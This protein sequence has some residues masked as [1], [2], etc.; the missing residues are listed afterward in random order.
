M[1]VGS[2]GTNVNSDAARNLA[3]TLPQR[4]ATTLREAKHSKTN[5]PLFEKVALAQEAQAGGGNVL[6]LTGTIVSLE[7]GS[8]AKRYFIGFGSG[9]AFTTVECTFTDKSSGAKVARATFDGELSM[10]LFG[11]SADE[12]TQGVL[13]SIVKYINDN[14]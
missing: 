8:R 5:K 3:A 13:N 9:K 7:E 4:I 2:F 10:G 1:E 12:A 6:F 14:Y 11:G